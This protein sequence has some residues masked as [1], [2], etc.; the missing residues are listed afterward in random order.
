MSG[1]IPGISRS[2]LWASWKDVR[3]QLKHSRLRD[4]IDYLDY[5]IDPE[6][7][8]KRILRQVANGTYEPSV[9][10]RFCL[11]KSSGFKR[12]LTLPHIPDLALFGAIASF[13]HRKAKRHQQPH[14]YY[15][16][17]DLQ[18]AMNPAANAALPDGAIFSAEY[19]FNSSR[20]FANWKEYQ[21]YR[22]HLILEKTYKYIVITDVTNFFDSVLHSEVSNAFRNYPIP[23]R[24]I[25]LLFYL[26]GKTGYSR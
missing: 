1:R 12:T 4:V 5:D 21:Q 3:S 11:A 18:G 20:S 16:R 24:L 25:G 19:R 7:W 6:V 22:K 13:V 2:S 15:R 9:P 17:A 26:F 14:V 23:S 10:R 8:F